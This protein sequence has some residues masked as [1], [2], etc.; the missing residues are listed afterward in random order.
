MFF[1]IRLG[2]SALPMS[3]TLLMRIITPTIDR[4]LQFS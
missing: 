3:L 4:V 1:C 2:F